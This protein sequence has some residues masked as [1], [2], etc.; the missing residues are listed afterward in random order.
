MAEI[1]QADNVTVN[2]WH[3]LKLDKSTEGLPDGSSLLGHL[4]VQQSAFKSDFRKLA[5]VDLKPNAIVHESDSTQLKRG[6]QK[7]RHTT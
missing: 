5:F 1:M 2:D 4:L 6:V 7:G 3:T